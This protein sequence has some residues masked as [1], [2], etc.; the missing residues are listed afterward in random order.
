MQR[1]LQLAANGLGNVSP[2]PMVGALVVDR[3]GYVIG[4]GFHRRYGE[5]H[6]EVNAVNSVADR[7][8]LRDST[9][10]VTLEPCSHYGKTPPCARLLVENRVP[11]VIVGALD[12]NPLVAGRGIAML[13]EAGIE[14]VTGILADQSRSLN[15][16]F[17]TS[18]TLHRP[19]V[20]LKWAQSADGFLDRRRTPGCPAAKFSTSLSLL[21]VHRL[22][23]IHDAILVGSGT[24]VADDPLLDSRLWGGK[25]PVPVIIGSRRRLP[26]TARIMERNPVI[27]DSPASIGSMLATLHGHGISSLL[28]EGGATV[29]QSFIDSGLWDVARV[30]TAPLHLASDGTPAAP[31]I[32]CPPVYSYSLSPNTIA[33]YNNPITAG[34]RP[35]PFI[36]PALSFS[37]MTAV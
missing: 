32:P 26:D 25:S 35:D 12:P 34:S 6:A 5:A 11:R 16:S 7:S 15:A 29:L 17:I 22:R 14:V 21:A 28:V 9:V 33:V 18:H 20:T 13:R 19:F 27:I 36:N 24:V 37:P 10:Y 23:A 8:M 31:V 4:Q 2:N 3:H 1:A 30:E